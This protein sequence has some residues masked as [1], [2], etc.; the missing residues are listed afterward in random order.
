MAPEGSHERAKARRLLILSAASHR[1][2]GV[3][4]AEWITIMRDYREHLV[5]T[6][7]EADL[8][9]IALYEW[10]VPNRALSK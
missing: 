5:E 3:S 2:I 6:V 7:G 10:T 8:Q 4:S 1:F 9:A